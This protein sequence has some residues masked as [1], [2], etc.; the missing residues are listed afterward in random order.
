MTEKEEYQLLKNI[1]IGVKQGVAKAIAK[2]KAAGHSIAIWR[3]GK[4]VKIPPEEI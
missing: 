1:D 2:H 3:D 4:I